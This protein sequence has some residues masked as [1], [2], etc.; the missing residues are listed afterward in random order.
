MNILVINGSP[1][2]QYSTTLQTVRYLEILYPAHTFTVLDAGAKIR[3]FEK[4]FSAAEAAIRQ[5]ELILFSYP[6]YTFLAPS[7]LHRF[8]SLMKRSDCAKDK[9]ATQLTTS[10]HFYD[11]TAHAYVRD[12]CLDMGMLW[13]DGLSADMDDLTTE[14]GRAQAEAFFEHILWQTENRIY[15]RPATEKAAPKHLPVT[16][17]AACPADALQKQGDIVIVADL[18]E[19][20]EALAAMIDRFRAVT[21]MPTRVVNIRTFPF[22]GGCL[23]CFRCASDGN[24]IYTDGFER[25]LREDIQQS[26]A[27]VIAFSIEDHS[28]GAR[29]KMYDDRQ[30]CNGH[31]TVTMGKPFG[32][33]VSGDLSAEENLRTVITARAEV[34]G[35]FLAG[36]AT[37]EFGPDGDIDAMSKTLCRA[38]ETGY[39]PPANFYGVG[40]MKIFRDLIWLMQGMMRADHRFYKSH[41]QY[42]FAQKQWPRMLAM[43]LVG[44]LMNNKKLA[45]KMGSKMNEGML[46]PYQKALDS[47]KKR[48]AERAVNP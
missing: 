24:C 10:K 36:V 12:N 13:M 26:A 18:K 16:V 27:I 19:E 31:R 39:T 37:D 43:Y 4:D 33:L 42:D 47:A 17:P 3:L 48:M 1:K 35:N 2:G 28:M 40:G 20:D 41:G 23:S 38:I 6:V 7:Q 11:M 14:K 22:K 9:P 34:G 45:G 8:I 46:M 29:F 44:G 32:Y 30:F 21:P 25:L 5:A 15:C